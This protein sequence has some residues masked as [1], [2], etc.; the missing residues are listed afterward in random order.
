MMRTTVRAP[1]PRRRPLALPGAV[2]AG[3]LAAMAACQPPDHPSTLPPDLPPAVWEHLTPDSARVTRIA[4]GVFYH[5]FWSA[6]GPW[7]VHVLEARMDRCQLGLEVVAAPIQ[8][9]RR[10]GR[11]T[12][13]DLVGSRGV[14]VVAAVNGDFFTPEGLP[15]GPEVVNG[16][17]RTGRER[18]ALVA[19]GGGSVPWI[20]VTG[21]TDRVVPSTGWP[22]GGVGPDA[23]QVVGGWPEL[24][25][26]GRRVGDL[27]VGAN[28]SFAASRHPRTA[29]G[30]NPSDRSLWFVVVD[31]R[32]G[33]YST[34]MTLPELTGLLEAMGAE[35]ALNLDG[36]GSS[37][38]VVRGRAVSHPS[39]DTGERAVANALLLVE[40]PSRCVALSGRGS[41]GLPPGTS[42]PVPARS[43]GLRTH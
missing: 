30:V 9:G 33:D 12:V 35:E 21:V 16:V 15:L 43:S 13:T 25:D 31:G 34:G 19:R 18:P 10:G 24:L 1:L 29:V 17:R 2:V 3:L 32:Q 5:F 8:P 27:L 7:A 26:G 41:P 36:G 20:G 42:G 40:D 6:R 28:P 14:A 39:D 37:V 38:L 4:D 22:L 11:A 23:V